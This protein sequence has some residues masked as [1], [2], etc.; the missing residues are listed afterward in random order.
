MK[1]RFGEESLMKMQCNYSY[2]IVGFFF[3]MLIGLV[4]NAVS[5]QNEIGTS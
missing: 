3:L 5:N 4:V 1:I 2:S